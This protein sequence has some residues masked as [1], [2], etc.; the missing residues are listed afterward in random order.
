MVLI[1]STVARSRRRSF[2]ALIAILILFLGIPLL[3]KAETTEGA[4]GTEPPAPEPEQF[5]RIEVVFEPDAYYT[6][7]EFIL[8]LT[9][10][11]MPRV[12]EKKEFEIYRMLLSRGAILPQFL[13]FEASVNPLPYLGV[14][15]KKNQPGFYED[16]QISGSFNWVQAVTAGFEEPYAVSFLAGN[17]V[18]FDVQ[19]GAETTGIGYSGYLYSAGNYHI[20]DNELIRDRWQELEWKMKGDRKSPARKL[21]WSFRV[22]A[23][24]HE[25][26][27]ITDMFYL[28]FRRSR[29]DYRPVGDS[30]LN[31]SGFEYTVDLNRDTFTP[32]RHYF[33]LD[34]KWPIESRKIAFT[35][36]TGFIWEAAGKYTGPLATGQ[37]AGYQFLLRPNIE[38]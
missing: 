34:K 13:V 23:K 31:N 1:R 10:A 12:G 24:F 18:G 15:L 19:E 37:G 35:L 7:I 25:N 32:I 21:S 29:L 30:L 17:V 20:K 28:S 5:K 8:S 38:F 22:G 6:N 14:Y 9:R 33:S 3:S 2:P 11:P 4:A 16:A 27:Y 36:A 26:P